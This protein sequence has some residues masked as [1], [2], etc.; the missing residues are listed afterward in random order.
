MASA[1]AHRALAADRRPRRDARTASTPTCSRRSSCSRSAGRPDAQ[2]SNDL[3]SAPS[4][5]T[6]ILAETGQNLLGMHIDVKASERADPRHPARAPRRGARARA[7]ARRRALRPGQGDRGDGALPGFRQG[8]ARPRRPRGR[9][10]TTWASATCSRRS[11]AYGKGD[12][13]YAQ[14]YFD[15]T[16]A[17]PRARRGAS[18]PRWATTPRPTCGGCWR[19]ARSCAC[20]ATTPGPPAPRRCS[21]PTRPR[22]RRSCTRPS[23][24]RSSATPSRSGARGRRASCAV[25]RPDRPRPLRAAASTR[26][27]G[28][29]AGRIKQSPRLYRALRPQA[30]AVLQALGAATRAISAQPAA[31]RHEH[32]ARQ[33]LPAR[34]RRDR[35]GGDARLL[36]AHHG[37]RLRHRPRV[38]QPRPGARLPVR[39]RPPGGARA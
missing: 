8:Q 26:S 11:P 12:V 19:P 5:L 25:D 24:R 7:P 33:G 1:A 21:S 14:L 29:L 13:P 23:A 18:S 17:A 28:E 4:G 39:A 35:T 27:M 38:P 2:A 22:P 20:T 6:Q 32:G 9:R 30:L 3:R 31:D 34:A 10:A 15:S 36:A 16:P 37:L